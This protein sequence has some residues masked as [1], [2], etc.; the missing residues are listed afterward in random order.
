MR[1]L[2]FL[3]FFNVSYFLD[4]QK[5]LILK[6]TELLDKNQQKENAGQCMLESESEAITL[7]LCQLLCT[8]ISNFSTELFN[9]V[10]IISCFCQR[11]F[12]FNTF[13]VYFIS[14]EKARF[15]LLLEK[16]NFGFGLNNFVYL[17]ATFCIFKRFLISSIRKAIFIL[18]WSQRFLTSMPYA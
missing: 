16:K 1:F 13:N 10:S 9:L 12:L 14:L 15:F 11:R 17:L 8:L 5:N 4:G 6:A 18:A 3:N 2:T 7:K